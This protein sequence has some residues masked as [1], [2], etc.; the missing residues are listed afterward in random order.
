MAN[1]LMNSWYVIVGGIVFLTLV[2]IPLRSRWYLGC[3][4]GLLGAILGGATAF[5]AGW[6]YVKHY[7]VVPRP[8]HDMDFNG[9]ETPIIFLVFIP[10][11]GT[12]VGFVL[13]LGCAYLLDQRL[14]DKPPSKPDGLELR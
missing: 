12:L 10:A 13:G 14:R 6:Y 9:L 5:G 8:R 11:L 4:F 1:S 2:V 3:G 7:H